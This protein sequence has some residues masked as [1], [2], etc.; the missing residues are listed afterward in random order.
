MAGRTQR[1]SA[2]HAICLL[3]YKRR[4]VTQC[5]RSP[6]LETCLCAMLCVWGVGGCSSAHCS[7]SRGPGWNGRQGPSGSGRGR[8]FNRVCAQW[9]PEPSA[10]SGLWPYKSL[11]YMFFWLGCGCP[12]QAADGHGRRETTLTVQPCLDRLDGVLSLADQLNSGSRW[13]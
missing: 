8:R 11:S 9:K 5:G 6:E 4:F 1:T 7:A 12:S 13:L 10:C 3:L 2:L